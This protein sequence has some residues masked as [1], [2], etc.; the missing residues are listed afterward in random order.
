MGCRLANDVS[1]RYNCFILLLSSMVSLGNVK[2]AILLCGDSSTLMNSPY[3][4]ET[5][6]LFGDAGSATALEFDVTAPDIVFHHGSKGRDF[7]AIITPVGGLRNPITEDAILFKEYGEHIVRRM[8]DCQ[9]D[10]MGVFAF[11]LKV[12]P[13]SFR[14]LIENFKSAR[15]KI[16]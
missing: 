16:Y 10:G 8:I 7:E 12:A 13:T 11:G 15:V 9:M 6:P 3:D 4:K 5:R 1:L 2:R 14:A